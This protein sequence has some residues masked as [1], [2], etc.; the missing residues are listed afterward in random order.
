[1]DT[2]RYIAAL[3]LVVTMPP[4]VV[5]WFVV[6][7]FAGVWRRLGYR[8]SLVVLLFAF[9]AGIGALA[10]LR[11]V[12][13]VGDLGTRWTLMPVAGA[14]YGLSLALERKCRK[15]LS[16]RI[17]VGIPELG[18]GSGRDDDGPGELLT[19][20]IYARVRHPRY[21]AVI[22]GAWGWALFANYTAGYVVAALLIPSL[23][24]LTVLEERELVERFGDAYRAYRT[25]VPRLIPVPG[26]A[27]GAQETRD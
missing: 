17:L 14:L 19:E 7:P 13:V 20:G 1:M 22:L 18:G 23:W 4:A 26:A 5:Y 27:A 12:L 3:V 15:H 9:F 24:V 25:R 2:A 8:W 16:F 6:H 10:A 21:L 11:D